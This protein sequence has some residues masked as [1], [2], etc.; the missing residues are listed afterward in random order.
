MDG[1]FR[2]IQRTRNNVLVGQIA[3][4]FQVTVVDCT[5]RIVKGDE[6]LLDVHGKWFAP[7]VRHNRAI[8][9]RSKEYTAHAGTRRVAGTVYTRFAWNQFSDASRA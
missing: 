8:L 6:V 7:K 1:F 4:K 9:Q 5:G 2:D 3:T